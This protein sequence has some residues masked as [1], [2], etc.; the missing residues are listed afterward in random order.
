LLILNIYLFFNVIGVD[1]MATKE[2]KKWMKIC[3]SKKRKFKE[4]KP[5]TWRTVSRQAPSI[6][7]NV[8]CKSGFF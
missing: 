4:T 3:P 2:A 6:E 5:T 8:P 7:K 1:L